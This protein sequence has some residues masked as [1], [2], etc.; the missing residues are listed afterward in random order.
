[1]HWD[2]ELGMCH[3]PVA[4]SN[5]DGCVQL[6]DL[7]DVLSAYL[8]VD[9]RSWVLRG[10]PLLTQSYELLETPMIAGGVRRLHTIFG[11]NNLEMDLTSFRLEL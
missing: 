5:L 11:M 4:L 9:L 6:N 2:W 7:L 10:D 1:M 8:S 3:P